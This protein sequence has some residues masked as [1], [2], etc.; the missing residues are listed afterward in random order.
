MVCLR[1]LCGS[2]AGRE[3]VARRFPLLVGR[4]KDADVRIEDPGVWEHHFQLE[5]DRE[6]G[7]LLTAGEEAVTRVD[8]RP[9]CR[10]RLRNGSVIE[11]G[12]ARLQFT[13]SPVVQRSMRWRERCV[14][15]GLGCL[16]MVE[17][18]I[19]RLLPP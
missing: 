10:E 16:V 14:W 13:L 4:A 11:A 1:V 19:L 18:A 15:G 9:V 12:S 8:G 2:T 3:F 6:E 5:W 7:I 17:L